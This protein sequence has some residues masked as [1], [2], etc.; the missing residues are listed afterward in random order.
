M[1][2]MKMGGR[3]LDQE[4]QEQTRKEE[5]KK[6]SEQRQMTAGYSSEPSPFGGFSDPLLHSDPDL[7]DIICRAIRFFS[8]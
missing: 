5:L 3:L 8:R 6:E 7:F 1:E 4:R 2:W